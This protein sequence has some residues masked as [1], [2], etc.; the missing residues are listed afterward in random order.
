MLILSEPRME[1]VKHDMGIKPDSSVTLFARFAM[2][3]QDQELTYD[4]KMKRK[5]YARTVE[6]VQ[7]NALPTELQ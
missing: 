3:Q 7:C 6:R 5:E 1:E 2:V 4:Y